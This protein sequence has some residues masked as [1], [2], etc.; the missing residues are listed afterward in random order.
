MTTVFGSW[1]ALRK[2]SRQLERRYSMMP[3]TGLDAHAMISIPH[4]R[5]QAGQK[6]E[7]TRVIRGSSALVITTTQHSRHQP[8]PSVT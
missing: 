1:E 2:D 6:I 7:S 3:L 8:I 4:R 5:H